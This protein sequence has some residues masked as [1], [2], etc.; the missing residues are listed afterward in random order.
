MTTKTK[1]KLTLC[2]QDYCGKMLTEDY[3]YMRG[4]KVYCLTHSQVTI[5]GKLVSMLCKHSTTMKFGSID[6]CIDCGVIIGN[7][8]QPE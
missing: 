7:G 3:V 1:E 5:T 2:S 8:S 4:D 6:E